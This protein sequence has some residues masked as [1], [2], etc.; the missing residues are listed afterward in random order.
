MSNTRKANSPQARYRP[1]RYV[2]PS[3]TSGTYRRRSRS[4]R[5]RAW[6][7][8]GVGSAFAD[9]GAGGQQ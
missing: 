3:T 7:K 2:P 9:F 6:V 8:Y 5:R 4:I 1:M